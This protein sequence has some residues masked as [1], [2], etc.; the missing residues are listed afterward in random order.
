MGGKTGAALL[1]GAVIVVALA[2]CGSSS[3]SASTVKREAGA[4]GKG[5]N[6][7]LVNGR[8]DTVDVRICADDSNNCRNESLSPN[9]HISVSARQVGGRLDLPSSQVEFNV[10]NPII[11]QP[12]IALQDDKGATSVDLSEGE[13]SNFTF[14]GNAF[15]ASRSADDPDYKVIELRLLQ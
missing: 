3:N 1:S 7:T 6:L 8:Q 12:Y 2:G 15:R 5:V 9:Q 13:S 14:S 4:E 11:G 10:A